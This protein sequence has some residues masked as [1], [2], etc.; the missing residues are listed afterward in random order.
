LYDNKCHT[1][2]RADCYL[3]QDEMDALRK[4]FNMLANAHIYKDAVPC[5]GNVVARDGGLGIPIAK[6]NA[7]AKKRDD[8]SFLTGLF[9]EK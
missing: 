4:K 3:V 2:N 7:Q 5:T 9:Y 6:M 1:R 8:L